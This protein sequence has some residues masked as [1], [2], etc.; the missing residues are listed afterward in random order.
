MIKKEKK[1]FRGSMEV[2]K[3]EYEHN[4]DS[5]SNSLTEETD[6]WGRKRTTRTDLFGTHTNT[7]KG[8]KA[9]Y[10]EGTQN[11]GFAAGAAIGT[12]LI[13]LALAGGVIY[14]AGK[15][16]YRIATIEQRKKEEEARRA[17]MEKFY[18]DY[19]EEE[20]NRI[21]SKYNLKLSKYNELLE[22]G[23][24]SEKEYNKY[25][26]EFMELSTKEIEEAKASLI[27]NLEKNK[28]K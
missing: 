20:I 7:D 26:K 6:W 13:P 25:V 12:A 28:K 16:I 22:L 21:L 8:F 5:H 15:L 14:G 2:S 3:D 9:E 19:C 1:Y 18:K 23:I 24:L 4:F 27:R 17:S 10:S 11:L